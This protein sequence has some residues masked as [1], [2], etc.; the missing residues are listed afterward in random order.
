MTLQIVEHVNWEKVNNL[1]P[2]IVQDSRTGQVLMLGYMN[3]ESL[4]QTIDSQKVTFYSRSKQR[5]WTKGESS[6]HFLHLE[7]IGYDCDNDTII[8]LVNPKG[9]ACH[10]GTTTCFTTN[11]KTQWHI[12]DRLEAVIQQR[13]QTMPQNSYVT[14]LFQSGQKR[15][16]QKVGEEAVESVIA[17]MAN[18]NEELK[19]ELAD[20]LF[21]VMVLLESKDL[22]LSDVL[23]VLKQRHQTTASD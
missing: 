6:G 14:T 2:A 21:H 3:P 11:F 20:L 9:P 5:L 13:K 16:S 15:I 22:A 12:L 7:Q 10:K 4:Q 18:N 17:S 23:A 8:V 19:N 1:V